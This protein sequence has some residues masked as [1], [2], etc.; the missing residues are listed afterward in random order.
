LGI[1]FFGQP[2]SGICFSFQKSGLLFG[3]SGFFMKAAVVTMGCRVNQAESAELL[4]L[5][6]GA[7]FEISGPAEAQAV[8]LNTCAVTQASEKEACSILRRLRR[9]NP[10]AV[11]AAVGCLAELAGPELLKQSLA[12]VVLGYRERGS[13]LEHLPVPPVPRPA[14]PAYPA[15]TRP[16]LKVQDGCS[17]SCTYCTVPLARGPSRSLEPALIRDR[18]AEFLEK[19]AREI[20]LT[21]VHLGHYGLDLSPPG[22]LAGLL[23]DI[24]RHFG[25]R[26]SFRLRLSSLEP[27]EVPLVFKALENCSWLVRHIHAP[28]QSGSHRI[29]QKMDRPYGRREFQAVISEL[30]G[31]FGPLALGTDVLAGFP[32]ETREDFEET[33]SLLEA[34]PFSYFHVFAYSPRR[35]TPAASFPEQVPLEEK[36]RR[37]RILLELGRLKRQ[38]FLETQ[39][40]L[41]HMA[42]IENTPNIRGQAVVLTESYIR[43][44]WAGPAPPPAGE[45]IRV[46]LSPSASDPAAAE[47]LPWPG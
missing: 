36:K 2:L 13:L 22:D 47:A 14:G 31:R 35:G 1:G 23:A 18:L 27:L 34:L 6:A 40:P 28:L 37:S 24:D 4:A 26:G 32:G 41:E 20:V 17:C 9:S 11:V 15:R 38:K 39:Y 7:G 16:L 45:L 8:I 10:R 21:G 43:A 33:R 30:S 3:F 29:L 44:P 19:G 42:L 5:L 12:D 46:R 25:S